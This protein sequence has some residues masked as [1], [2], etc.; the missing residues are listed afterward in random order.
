MNLLGSS[1]LVFGGCNQDDDY[2]N[3][4][5]TFDLRQLHSRPDDTSWETLLPNESHPDRP[6]ARWN[7]TMVSWDD[8][9]FL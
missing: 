9:L 6:L 3:D 7:H 1:I 4:L 5:S 8:K 2:F